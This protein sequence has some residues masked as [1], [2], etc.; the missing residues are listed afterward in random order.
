MIS[1]ELTFGGKVGIM[2]GV[3]TYAIQAAMVNIGSVSLILPLVSA[4]I[5]GGVA[6]GL[7]KANMTA[8][9]REIGELKKELHEIRRTG[10]DALVRVAAI[11]GALRAG[12]GGD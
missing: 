3:A 1:A 10:Q 11:E 2:S 6:W 9:G 5:G 7:M 4:A 12:H 8:M